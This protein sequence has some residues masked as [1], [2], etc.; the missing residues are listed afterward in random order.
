[1]PLCTERHAPPAKT[2]Q[3]DRTL[4]IAILKVIIR[5]AGQVL[6]VWIERGGHL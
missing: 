2:R 6:Q 3:A 4:I 5:T 1:M